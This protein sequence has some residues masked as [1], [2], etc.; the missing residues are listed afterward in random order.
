LLNRWGFAS[1]TFLF[2]ATFSMTN[3]QTVQNSTNI[4]EHQQNHRR[5][6]LPHGEV[7][8]D[9]S[10]SARDRIASFQPASLNKPLRPQPMNKKTTRTQKRTV[11]KR[12]TVSLT[13]WVPSIVKETLTQ[14]AV[15]NGISISTTGGTLLA[16]ALQEETDMAYGALLEPAIE[17]AVHRQLGR[18]FSG[19]AQLLVRMGYVAEQCRCLI[20]ALLSRRPGMQQE[21]LDHLLDAAALAAKRRAVAQTAQLKDLL[22]GMKSW[23]TEEPAE[24]NKPS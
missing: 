4:F 6:E 7:R 2:I 8:Q 23:F 20:I 16:K 15:S 11:P 10:A 21:T 17:Q 1:I 19:I 22:V 5:E 13:L 14:R 9:K 12:R 3:N 18:Y 24:Q